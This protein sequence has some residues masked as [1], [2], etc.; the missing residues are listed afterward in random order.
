MVCGRLGDVRLV[1]RKLEHRAATVGKKHALNTLW[2]VQRPD[3]DPSR[4][5]QET[6]YLGDCADGK[7]PNVLSN[8][9]RGALRLVE[10][11]K[12][13]G[14]IVFDHAQIGLRRAIR[15]PSALF[16]VSKRA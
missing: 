13:R 9:F 12:D 10:C 7:M 4:R 5:L 15:S 1:F 14:R 2:L 11:S 3:P 6:G 16:P 8:Q